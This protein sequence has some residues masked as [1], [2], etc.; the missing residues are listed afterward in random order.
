MMVMMREVD[1]YWKF[2]PRRY[3]TLLHVFSED[4]HSRR[5]EPESMSQ[6]SACRLDDQENDACSSVRGS[7]VTYFPIAYILLY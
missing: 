2:G 4:S 3:E 5:L 7:E 1:C 6:M